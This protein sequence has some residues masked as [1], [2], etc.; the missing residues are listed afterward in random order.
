M[1]T[2]YWGKTSP[3]RLIPAPLL[4][5]ADVLARK[6][7]GLSG[8]LAPETAACLRKL[9]IDRDAEY[10]ESLEGLPPIEFGPNF[11]DHDVDYRHRI[12]EA[13]RQ[14]CRGVLTATSLG[15]VVPLELTTEQSLAELGLKPDLWLLGKATHEALAKLK[16]DVLPTPSSTEPA[17][18]C[19]ELWLLEMMLSACIYQV[20]CTLEAFLPSV[21]RERI[22]KAF[23]CDKQILET[24]IKKESVPAVLCVFV[25]GS[26]P[27][28]EFEMFTGLPSAEARLEVSKLEN[29]GILAFS[30]LKPES[31]VPCLPPWLGAHLL[32]HLDLR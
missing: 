2:D 11:I 18:A 24:K 25:Q 6:A 22:H 5:L 23:L 8:R 13:L 12:V 16:H 20:N 29:L 3:Q 32:P 15:I 27:H 21:L 30:K 17:S 14:H 7:A 1:S 31:L 26:L 28:G 10:V 19:N 9:F 4:D